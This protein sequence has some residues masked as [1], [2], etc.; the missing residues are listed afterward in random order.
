MSL[1]MH[2]PT[3][4]SDLPAQHLLRFLLQGEKGVHSLKNCCEGKAKTKGA[5]LPLSFTLG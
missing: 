5:K 2:F 1:S 3:S 4:P